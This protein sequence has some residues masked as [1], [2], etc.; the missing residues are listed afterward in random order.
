MGLQTSPEFPSLMEGVVIIGFLVAGGSVREG[1]QAVAGR[2]WLWQSPTV[3]DHCCHVFSNHLQSWQ[4]SFKA[5]VK[6]SIQ[7]RTTY[8]AGQHTME[9]NMQSIRVNHKSINND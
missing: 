9:G 5:R 8:N 2:G 6:D 7:R 1:W 4:R 3:D